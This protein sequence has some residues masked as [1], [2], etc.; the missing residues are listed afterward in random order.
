[1]KLLKIVHPQ[2]LSN[3]KRKIVLIIYIICVFNLLYSQ[4]DYIFFE[5][6]RIN[7]NLKIDKNIVH[8]QVLKIDS[9]YN[10]DDKVASHLYFEGFSDRTFTSCKAGNKN[11]DLASFDHKDTFKID[12]INNLILYDFWKKTS[13][14]N[15]TKKSLKIKI[16]Q[17][18]GNTYYIKIK[19]YLVKGIFAKCYYET[20][21]IYLLGGYLL[22]N[23]DVISDAKIQE[24]LNKVDY[25][26]LFGQNS[27]PPEW[28]SSQ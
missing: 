26:S 16:K 1:M 3:M 18:D 8:F 19:Y 23:T 22:I 2:K 4:D 10:T 25:N 14:K 13:S 5:I 28:Q 27:Y 24:L 12:S 11:L 7:N 21:S 17:V 9:L 20:N 15:L 6:E